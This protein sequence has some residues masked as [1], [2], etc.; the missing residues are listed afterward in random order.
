MNAPVR[1]RLAPNTGAADQRPG[2]IVSLW[3][4]LRF[5]AERFVSA[6]NHL[7]QLEVFLEHDPAWVF[8]PE[9]QADF[10]RQADELIAVLRPMGLRLTLKKAETF[11]F[12][13]VRPRVDQL[14][15]FARLMRRHIEDIR[16]RLEQ[17]LEGT[18]IY[19]FSALTDYLEPQESLFGLEVD[20]KFPSASEEI[21]E[22]GKC[23]ALRR[24]TACVMHLMRVLELGLN[25]LAH[26]FNVPFAHTN[27]HNI[28]EQIERKIKDMSSATHG[29]DWKDKQQFFSEVATEF[30]HFK[31]AW[32]NH[33][34]HVRQTYT[35]ER[36]ER[37]FQSVKSF[38]QH[39][40]TRLKEAP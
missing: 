8:A 34:M 4:M 21:E 26:D 20:Q 33:A 5:Y 10:V 14:D 2:H 22:A 32:R 15:I 23:L 9:R 36:A 3:D 6:L 13:L 12:G 28:V 16:E 25:S 1:E 31:S 19:S 7:Q 18:V 24:A 35:E 29:P 39:L 11:R 37:I 30:R 38:M 27:W 17:E 40:A